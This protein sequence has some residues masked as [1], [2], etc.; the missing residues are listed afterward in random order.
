MTLVGSLSGF[1][2]KTNHS[3]TDTVWPEQS[4]KNREVNINWEQQCKNNPL[5]AAQKGHLCNRLVCYEIIW[6]TEPFQNYSVVSTVWNLICFVPFGLALLFNST[7]TTFLPTPQILDRN[8]TI[9][10]IL[11]SN[12]DLFFVNSA[13][14]EQPIFLYFNGIPMLKEHSTFL[15]NSLIL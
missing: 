2:G 15:E 6:L 1:P 8:K 10:R 9:P 11:Q 5:K 14:R 13:V 7:F 12:G 4:I 3:L